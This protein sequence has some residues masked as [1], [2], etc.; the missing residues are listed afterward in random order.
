[1][2]RSEIRAVV[3]AVTPKKGKGDSLVIKLETSFK[4]E[5]LIHFAEAMMAGDQVTITMEYDDTPLFPAEDEEQDELFEEE[6]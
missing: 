2:V 4:E 1:M 3:E 6:K 5:T